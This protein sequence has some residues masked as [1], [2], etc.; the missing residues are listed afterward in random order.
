M[1]QGAESQ[2]MQPSLKSM[3]KLLARQHQHQQ[4]GLHFDWHVGVLQ[5]AIPA[6]EI[7]VQVQYLVLVGQELS[8]HKRVRTLHAAVRSE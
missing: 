6:C 3:R 5:Q 8:Q 7:M 1:L 2:W 4:M